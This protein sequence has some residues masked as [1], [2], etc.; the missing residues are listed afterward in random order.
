MEELKRGEERGKLIKEEEEE[1]PAYASA[2]SSLSR[3]NNN[4]MYNDNDVFK[5]IV[6]SSQKSSTMGAKNQTQ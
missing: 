4:K 5:A 3:S 2:L 1:R 6:N